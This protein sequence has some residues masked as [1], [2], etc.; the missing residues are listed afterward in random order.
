MLHRINS[1]S[2][3]IAEPAEKQLLNSLDSHLDDL[4]SKI[5]QLN[6]QLDGEPVVPVKPPTTLS[7]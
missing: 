1:D 3:G 6:S 4:F 2:G 7:K 5:T